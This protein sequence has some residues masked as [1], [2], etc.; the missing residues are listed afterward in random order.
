MG[1]RQFFYRDRDG[2]VV[3]AQWPNAA[4]IAWLVVVDRRS[5]DSTSSRRRHREVDS[6]CSTCRSTTARNRHGAP[7][8]SG[9]KMSGP[10]GRHTTTPCE[11]GSTNLASQRNGDRRG[12]PAVT[13]P[14]QSVR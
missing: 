6:R 5:C 11:I 4:L 9:P 8:T 3:L 13:L 7:L 10:L 2:H 1:N 12:T 14:P